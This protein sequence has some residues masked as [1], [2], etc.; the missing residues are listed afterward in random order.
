[1]SSDLGLCGLDDYLGGETAG[2]YADEPSEPGF[3]DRGQV[4]LAD[5]ASPGE[6]ALCLAL[7]HGQRDIHQWDWLDE[8]S[9]VHSDQPSR[10]FAWVLGR[11]DWSRGPARWMTNL[12][13]GMHLPRA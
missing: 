10:L 1:V 3:V 4:Y 5:R 7:P 12:T 6:H 2:E 8:I 9:D 13:D 11:I